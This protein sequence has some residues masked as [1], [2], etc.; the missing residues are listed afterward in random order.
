[1]QK[2]TEITINGNNYEVIIIA[3]DQGTFG[4]VYF[5]KKSGDTEDNLAFKFLK[6][7]NNIESVFN[8]ET[9]LF[10]ELTEKISQGCKNTLLI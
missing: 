5:G 6:T 8:M 10:K 2:Y 7:N 1:M 3:N 4:A 9:L